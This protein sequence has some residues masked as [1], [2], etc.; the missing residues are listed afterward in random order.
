VSM[1]MNMNLTDYS[2][3]CNHSRLTR[4]DRNFV[5]CL[6]CGQSMISQK[7]ILANKTRQDF[8]KENKSFGRN[9]DRNFTNVIEETDQQN[10]PLLEFYTDKLLANTIIINRANQLQSYPPKYRVDINGDHAL[11]TDEQIN[12]LLSDI[13]AVRINGEQLR[14]MYKN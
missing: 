10:V 5:R 13:N 1:N 3:I 7:K 2:K 14:M 4:L 9:F 6:D 12:K 8:T 11:L